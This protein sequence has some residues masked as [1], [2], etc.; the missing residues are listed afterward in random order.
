MNLVFSSFT[1]NPLFLAAVS[2]ALKAST[3]A[4]LV[5]P[6]ISTAVLARISSQSSRHCWRSQLPHAS[7]LIQRNFGFVLGVQQT[8]QLPRIA[9]VDLVRQL[10]CNLS[11]SLS[12]HG[13]VFYRRKIRRASRQGKKF[14]LV[15]DEEPL[16]NA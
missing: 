7:T 3:M 1:V 15:I 16:D 10:G 13:H 6:M 4:A 9:K 2:S 8:K 12:N 5:L 14:N 11:Q